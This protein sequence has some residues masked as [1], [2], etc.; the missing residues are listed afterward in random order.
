MEANTSLSELIILNLFLGSVLLISGVIF[1]LIIVFRNKTKSRKFTRIF[2][3]LLLTILSSIVGSLIL[4]KF[5][6]FKIDIM[7][8]PI[9]LPLLFA[10]IIFAPL[11]LRVFGYNILKR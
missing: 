5:W 1:Q 4:W 9:L 10:E 2:L 11:M 3:L 8:G 7:L 6:N